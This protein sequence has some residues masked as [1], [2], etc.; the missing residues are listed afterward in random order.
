MP[1]SSPKEK[2]VGE[3]VGSILGDWESLLPPEVVQEIHDQVAIAEGEADAEAEPQSGT[4]PSGTT[5][6]PTSDE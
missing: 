3:L 5:P 2:F 6:R 4:V 1:E